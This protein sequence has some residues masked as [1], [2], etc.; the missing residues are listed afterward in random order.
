MPDLPTS[1][2]SPERASAS[3]GLA[4]LAR[5]YIALVGLLGLVLLILAPRFPL[6]DLAGFVAFLILGGL[7]Q[8]MPI[9][10][11]KNASVS[12]AMAI[13]L[14][15]MIVFGPGASAWVNVA[16][17]L[18]H[19]TRQIRPQHKPFYRSIATTATLVIAATL[20]G[21]IYLWAGG[22]V[23]RAGNYLASIPAVLLA[24]LVYYLTN[25]ILITAAMALEQ[26]VSFWVLIR[27]TTEW[28]LVNIASLTPLALGIALVYQETGL[29]ALAIY[30]I[31]FA[32]ARYSFQLYVRSTEDV[33]KANADLKAANAELAR[34]GEQVRIA[35][36]DLRRANE[37]LNVMYQVSRSVVG[38]LHL[39]ETVEHLLA[40][41]RLM[42]F[43]AGLVA[44]AWGM[45]KGQWHWRTRPA[46]APWLFPSPDSSGLVTLA[47]RLAGLP[48]ETCFR[49]GELTVCPEVDLGLA[50][51]PGQASTLVLIPLFVDRR[52]WGAVGAGAPHALSEMEL[53]ELL[54]FRSIAEN[55]ISVALVH[56]QAERD[57]LIDPCT[58]LYNHRYFQEA[59]QRELADAMRRHGVLSLLML[60]IDHF[61]HFNDA[62]GHLVGDHVLKAIARLLHDNVRESD[63]ACRY[64]G[65]EMCVL[66]PHTAGSSALEAAMRIDDA[67][68][69]F[70]FRI[71]K[72]SSRRG[73][74]TMELHLR[75]SIGLATFP[76]AAETRAGLIEQADRAC[77]RA[78]ASGGGVAVDSRVPLRVPNA[79]PIAA[80]GTKGTVPLP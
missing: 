74:E 27:G 6:H 24:G 58:G 63:I 28:L 37:R 51:V 23:G 13:A 44:G 52:P 3:P 16:S 36:Q 20:S 50:T 32:L 31:P 54:L 17:G 70:N 18:V 33:Q 38:S 65:D 45:D 30:L 66:M 48:D 15:A 34:A 35:N 7:A 12:M 39:E 56:E 11:Y 69:A 68:R 46:Q 71:P 61:K 5:L 72:E 14:A 25:S 78:K 49:A 2:S 77:Y 73:S 62:Y 22:T 55:A 75:V 43:P 47:Q 42:G 64:G 29:L 60:D 80:R 79:I 10:F 19:Y 26:R 40:A 67:V 9:R 76:E 53:K 59:L 57:A 21:E 8:L 41:T 4:P 1:V